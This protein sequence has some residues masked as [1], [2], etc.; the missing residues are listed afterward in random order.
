MKLLDN[1]PHLIK[2]LLRSYCEHAKYQLLC[3]TSF[4]FVDDLFFQIT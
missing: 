4:F 3:K 1:M 2:A